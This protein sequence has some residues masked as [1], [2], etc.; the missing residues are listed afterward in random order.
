MHASGESLPVSSGAVR[1]RRVL[2][3]SEAVA[4]PLIARQ[5]RVSSSA[6]LAAAPASALR[7]PTHRLPI[8]VETHQ[9]G[10]ALM[11]IGI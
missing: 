6:T 2:F 7:P 10:G 3:S 11:N 5:A 4:R 8:V 9:A 1:D